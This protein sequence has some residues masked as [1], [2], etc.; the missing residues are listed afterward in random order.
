MNAGTPQWI[1]MRLAADTRTPSPT[2][3]RDKGD[4]RSITHECTP[5]RIKPDGLVSATARRELL[6]GK[7]DLQPAA[8]QREAR[9]GCRRVA[10]V[11]GL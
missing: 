7:S 9:E 10:G 2:M 1:I 11:G 3:R 5:Y 8:V 6:L 4:K